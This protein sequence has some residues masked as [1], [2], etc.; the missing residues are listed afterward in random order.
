MYR[1][2]VSGSGSPAPSCAD[3]G[4]ASRVSLSGVE[5][6]DRCF[7]RRVSDRMG[8]PVLPDPPAEETL[9]G[10]D[11]RRHRFAYRLWRAPTGIVAEA[12]ELGC[13]GGEGYQA[14]VLGSHDADTDALLARLR[15]RLTERVAHLDLEDHPGGRPLMAG[16][17]LEG[18]LVWNEDDGPY[19][20]VVDGRR[21]S[22]EAFGRALEPFE[23]WRFRLIIEDVEL[24]DDESASGAADRSKAPRRL[25]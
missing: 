6:C 14:S 20:V 7:D 24:V 17:E 18:R 19:D 12:D 13:A 21:L 10:P 16:D 2:L 1:C 3:C 11:G 5:L 22:W 15:V 8:L 4:L 25:H 9:T 23:G